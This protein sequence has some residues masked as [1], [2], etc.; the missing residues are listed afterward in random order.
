MSNELKNYYVF[1]AL[2]WDVTHIERGEEVE[3][4]DS[5]TN[6]DMPGYYC[7]DC[8]GKTLDGKDIYMQVLNYTPHFY[9][10]IPEEYASKWGK[11]QI[12][13]LVQY[14]EDCIYYKY[15]DCL[16]KFDVVKRCD[17]NGFTNGKRKKF[18]R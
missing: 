17:M 6:T 11:L 7:L 18:L 15:K 14:L 8:Y 9:V 2:K 13:K 1:Q 16:V 10:K 4:S 12:N 5:P 3:E